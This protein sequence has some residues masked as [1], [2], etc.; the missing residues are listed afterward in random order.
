[1]D[2]RFA[3]NGYVVDELIGF[4]GTGEVWRARDVAT[5]EI[6]ALKRLRSR[7]AAATERLRR[8]A[9]LLATVAGPHVIGVRRLIVDGHEA[10][11]VMDYA[12]GGSLAGV[13]G[14]RG[15]L[16]PAEVVTILAPIAAALAAAH[17]RDLVHGDITPANILF[18]ADG[19]PLLADFGV[20]HA[21]GSP[22]LIVE[23]TVDFLD[24]AVAAGATPV[25]ASDVF[26]LGAVGF[27]ALAG[28][29]LWGSGTPDQIQARASIGVRPSLEEL[30]ADAPSPLVAAIESALR[31]EPDE[32]P[33]ARALANE[34]LRACAAAPVR[35]VVTEVPAAPPMTHP[36]RALPATNGTNLR[37][38]A[39]DLEP[40]PAPTWIT[41]LSPGR[42]RLY[43]GVVAAASMVGAA[44]LGI[45]LGH[46]GPRQAPVL[47]LA[48]HNS[49]IAKIASAP[50]RLPN[51][52]WTVV[53]AQL[54]KLR[55]SAFANGDATPLAAVYAPGAEA[56][57][58]DKATVS[59]LASRGLRARGFQAT[60]ERVTVEAGTSTTE[61]LRVVDRLSGYAL[62]DAAGK[63]VGRGAPR[64]PRPFTMELTKVSGSWRIETIAPV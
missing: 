59:S 18:A 29:P 41:S 32:R 34:V 19:R 49:A 63:V 6:V 58:T 23:G 60:V 10:V 28:Q 33:D 3:L 57:V 21:L 1:M 43:V 14:V 27:T 17:A 61:K 8:E 20:A 42:R 54:D 36:V 62:V 31:L 53:V 56:Y 25:A 7:G 35:L 38:P 22:Q 48:P 24:P 26:S 30:A 40:D 37:E 4:G 16:P 2:E 9:A 46:H 39:V 11:L 44:F 52:K 45:A 55:T 51:V 15:R 50:D 64:P 12:A 13:L 5:G 47:D